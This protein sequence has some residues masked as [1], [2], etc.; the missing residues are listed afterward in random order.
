MRPGFGAIS[1]DGTVGD[2]VEYLGSEDAHSDLPML[3]LVDGH[4]H[5]LG[6]VPAASMRLMQARR[7][8]GVRPKTSHRDAVRL[9]VAYSLSAV[10]VVHPSGRFLGR[11]VLDDLFR[12]L[13]GEAVEG[14]HG[15]LDSDDHHVL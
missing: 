15:Y 8:M 7:A 12:I 3:F 1:E 14:V 2:A 6:V 5:P 11:L 13:R 9:A 4:E 10:P